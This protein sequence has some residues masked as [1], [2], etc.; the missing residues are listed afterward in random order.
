MPL[1]EE[2]TCR[3]GTNIGKP[4]LSRPGVFWSLAPWDSSDRRGGEGAGL[5]AQPHGQ[6]RGVEHREGARRDPRRSG[7]RQGRALDDHRHVVRVVTQRYG[8]DRTAI[9]RAA[10]KGDH[11]YVENI[12]NKFEGKPLQVLESYAYSG[13]NPL[14]SQLWS[15]AGEIITNVNTLEPAGEEGEIKA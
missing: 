12:P 8:P 14:N 7:Q 6:Q 1:A 2:A 10:G 4:R 3:T 15:K 9:R 5:A 13:E 11:H